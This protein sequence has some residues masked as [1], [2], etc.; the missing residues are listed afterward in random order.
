MSVENTY[1]VRTKRM[2]IKCRGCG[3]VFFQDMFSEKNIAAACK[4]ENIKVKTLD[5]PETKLGYWVTLEYGDEAP[6]IVEKST[7]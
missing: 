5:A 2:K 6:L 7:T 4:C 3:T 1:Y